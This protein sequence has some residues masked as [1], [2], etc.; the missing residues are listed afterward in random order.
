MTSFFT[1]HF[2]P[3]YYAAPQTGFLHLSRSV[4]SGTRPGHLYA[5]L[6]HTCTT[7]CM[8][9]ALCQASPSDSRVLVVR[10]IQSKSRP[11]SRQVKLQRID[12][13]H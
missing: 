2:E 1:G 4:P 13:K 10:Y 6:A 5:A 3:R 9:P 11:D 12:Q 7:L 8:Q